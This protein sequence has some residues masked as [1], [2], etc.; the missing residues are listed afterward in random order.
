LFVTLGHFLSPKSR[1]LSPEF[2]IS[3]YSALSTQHYEQLAHFLHGDLH[4][5][6]L[7]LALARARVGARALAADGQA[8]DVPH[9][10]PRTDLF[11][12]RDVHLDA[13]AQTAFHRTRTAV[14]DVF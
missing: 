6:G 14:L 11:Q 4:G 10:A 5:H 2:F 8:L 3:E 7:L 13:A 9:A 1:V 12:A